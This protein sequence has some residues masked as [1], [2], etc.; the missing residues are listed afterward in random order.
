MN[1]NNI[2]I[3]RLALA[4]GIVAGGALPSAHAQLITISGGSVQMTA[5]GYSA[6]NLGFGTPGAKP[7]TSGFP[8]SSWGIFQI[9]S[10]VD[11]NSTPVFAD[12][13]G[14]EYWGM[15]YNTYDSAVI[16]VGNTT[17]FTAKDLLLDIYKITTADALNANFI[18]MANLGTGQR[19]SLNTFTGITDVGTLVFKSSLIGDM[20]SSYTLPSGNTSAN[21]TLN[22]DFNNLFDTGASSLD[23]LNFALGGTT[24][25]D[26]AADW[27]VAFGGTIRG[28]LT[29]VPEPST[30]G[31]MGVGALV[32]IVALRRRQ[33]VAQSPEAAV[34]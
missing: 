22:I 31:L 5:N 15:Y 16:P 28:D 7:T 34:A 24:V 25:P 3:K 27:N 17:L 1:T 29:P 11:G 20:T 10:I 33:R 30:Y 32:G 14:T 9:T 2:T 6:S 18:G 21:G 19:T 4:L 26:V 8:E 13:L 23:E 12:N